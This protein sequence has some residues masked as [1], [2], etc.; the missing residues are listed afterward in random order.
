[1]NRLGPRSWT[2]A[3][4]AALCGAGA[5]AQSG[6]GVVYRCP[7]PPVLYTDTLT[8]AEAKE[9]GCRTIEGAPVTVM[10][11]RPR[12][13]PAPAA[14]SAAPAAAPAGARVDP[15]EQRRR[16]SDRRSILE[17]ELRREE[18][19]LAEMRR[20][21]ND[22]QPERLGSERNYQR[23]LDRVAQMRADIERKEGDIAAIKRELAKLPN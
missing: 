5:A 12:P 20:E 21:Y 9:R 15:A 3:L 22:G 4:V 8:P 16:D 23:Y 6:G 14:A 7:G 13:A 17:T 11:S 18:Q 1:M 10:Q 2:L 19:K